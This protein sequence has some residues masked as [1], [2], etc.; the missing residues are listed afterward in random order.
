MT[1]GHAPMHSF[2]KSIESQNKAEVYGTATKETCG[3]G[4]TTRYPRSVITFPSDKQKSSLH[5]TQKPVAL[6]EYLIQT[7]TNE[8][9]LVLDSCAGSM[10]TAI[11]AIN[12]GR[13]CICIEKDEE[14]YKIGKK[15]VDDYLL[16]NAG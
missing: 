9:D 1:E 5:S 4:A 2:T 7:Y 8:G 13:D 10:T 3:G 6:I 14:I 16:Q 15:R 11:A 12:T